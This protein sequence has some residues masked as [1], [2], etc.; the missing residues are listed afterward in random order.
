MREWLFKDKTTQDSLRKIVSVSERVL[1]DG[2]EV[3]TQRRCTYQVKDRTHVSELSGPAQC[4]DD[5]CNTRPQGRHVYVIRK[6]DA[7]KGDKIFCK[8]CGILYV[9]MGEYLYMIEFT[10]LLKIGIR[11]PEL[12]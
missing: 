5:G 1:Q 3:V 9:V 4:Q 12:C 2:V 7:I 11:P 8:V 10:N 6:R